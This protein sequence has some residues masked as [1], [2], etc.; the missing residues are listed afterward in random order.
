MEAFE[1]LGR[2]ITGAGL[3]F[4]MVSFCALAGTFALKMT[5]RLWNATWDD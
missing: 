1:T 4:V 3:L 5:A 2:I